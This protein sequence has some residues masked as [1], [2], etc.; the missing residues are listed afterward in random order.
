MGIASLIPI[1]ILI[2]ITRLPSRAKIRIASLFLVYVVKLCVNAGPTSLARV[3]SSI[4]MAY[5]AMVPACVSGDEE[6]AHIAG[7]WYVRVC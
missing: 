3:T 6:L 7:G 2:L 5:E 4:W 1:L